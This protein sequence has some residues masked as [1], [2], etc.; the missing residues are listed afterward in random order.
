MLASV[1]LNFSPLKTLAAQL[2]NS[3][4]PH[5]YPSYAGVMQTNNLADMPL[6]KKKSNIVFL[7]L[8]AIANY[9]FLSI[10]IIFKAQTA[11]V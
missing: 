9:F 10:H 8:P 7:I 1:C 5:T 11:V 2:V 4:H 3:N 6:A